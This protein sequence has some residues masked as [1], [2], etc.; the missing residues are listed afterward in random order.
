MCK[1]K[2][3]L[4]ILFST[5]SQIVS[6]QFVDYFKIS[7]DWIFIHDNIL[8]KDIFEKNR[9]ILSKNK[10][11]EIKCKVNN[12]ENLT[13]KYE[14][15]KD[16]LISEYS[17]FNTFPFFEDKHYSIK[18]FSNPSESNSLF[19][20]LKSIEK[21]YYEKSGKQKLWITYLFSNAGYPDSIQRTWDRSDSYEIFRFSYNNLIENKLLT[22]YTDEYLNDSINFYGQSIFYDSLN[23]VKVF[24][25]FQNRVDSVHRRDSVSYSG[26]TI[27][28]S[29]FFSTLK[30]IIKDSRIV[31]I[32]EYQFGDMNSDPS[33]Y[34][35]YYRDDELI[36]SIGTNFKFSL[37]YKYIF[38]DN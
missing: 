3:I 22:S 20:N 7:Y 4:I 16:G 25:H 36:D 31:K 5:F 21:Y 12:K 29:D 35:F 15:R 30:Y 34:H 18:Y 11:A 2:I 38:Y 19:F 28:F 23:R 33:I 1:V 17:E 24:A 26:D 32:L 27:I 10:V 6:A 8:L 9:Q 14:V 37:K 13:C